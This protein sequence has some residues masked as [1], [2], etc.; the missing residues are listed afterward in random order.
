M[1]E[2]QAGAGHG[3][4][5]D[6]RDEGGPGDGSQPEREG[7]APQHRDL[8]DLDDEDRQGLGGQQAGAAEGRGTEAL[9]HAVLAVE[10][11]G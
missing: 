6:G 11:G 7:H 3:A 8:H 1:A 4:Q 5:D 2:P 10:A 9:Q